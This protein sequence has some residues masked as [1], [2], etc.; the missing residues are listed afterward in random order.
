MRFARYLGIVNGSSDE[1]SIVVDYK[2]QGLLL[3]NGQTPSF[4]RTLLIL[5]KNSACCKMF[6]RIIRPL[7]CRSVKDDCSF[8]TCD[9]AWRCSKVLEGDSS[10]E[11]R[12]RRLR[13]SN[14]LSNSF[15]SQDIVFN[16]RENIGTGSILCDSKIILCNLYLNVCGLSLPPSLLDGLV[17]RIHAQAAEYSSECSSHGCDYGRER[18]NPC[19]NIVFACLSVL[20]FVSGLVVLMKTLDSQRYVVAR[21]CIGI[22]LEA[23]CV[24]AGCYA[25][26]LTF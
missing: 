5:S 4:D 12:N 2:V 8:N 7:T 22:M 3:S 19:P 6:N 11:S 1:D 9:Y 16:L 24:A 25:C 17:G 26:V 13:S 20:S 15:R 18:R 21:L 14:S 23:T 10:F